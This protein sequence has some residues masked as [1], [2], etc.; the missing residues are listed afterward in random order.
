MPAAIGFALSCYSYCDDGRSIYLRNFLVKDSYRS[1]GVDNLIF[2]GLLKHAKEMRCTRIE[3]SSSVLNVTDQKFYE[4]MGMI[5][6]T[7]RDGQIHFC[8]FKDA[9]DKV[10]I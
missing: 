6:V 2:R 1:K 3:L 7:K 4:K 9:I 5:N 8:L 10:E